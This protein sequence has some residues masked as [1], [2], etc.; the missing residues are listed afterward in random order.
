MTTLFLATANVS[1][2]LA[3]IPAEFWWKVL[4]AVALVALIVQVLRAITNVNKV[5][6]AVAVGVFVSGLGV[7]WVYERNEP[8]WAQPAV[9]V[10]ATFL[11]TKGHA[12]RR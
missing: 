9:A 8:T 1:D 5:M 4:A 7:R 3:Q 12:E 10:V 11:P 6:L 2:R